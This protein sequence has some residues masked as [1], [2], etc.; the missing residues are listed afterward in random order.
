MIVFDCCHAGTMTRGGDDVR[1]ISRLVDF[2][3]LK[4]KQE[5]IEAAKRRAQSCRR[6]D[7]GRSARARG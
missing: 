3:K 5:D 7:K 4:V 6:G 1:E 2:E